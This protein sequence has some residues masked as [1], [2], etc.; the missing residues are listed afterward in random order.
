MSPAAGSSSSDDEV[1]DITHDDSNVAGP[2]QHTSW[3]G[4]DNWSPYDDPG[5]QGY[6]APPTNDDNDDSDD[7]S[8]D[9]DEPRLW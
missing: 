2:S 5:F 3:P 1:E 7:D 4:G 8:D 9:D 6:S